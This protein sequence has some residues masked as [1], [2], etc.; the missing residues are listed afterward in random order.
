MTSTPGN[1]GPDAERDAHLLAALRHAP[2]AALEPPTSLSTR[3][4][5]HA[6]AATRGGASSA[7]RPWR[8]TLASRLAQWLAPRAPWAAAF[9]TIAAATLVGVLWSGRHPPAEDGVPQSS[10]PNDVAATLAERA[11]PNPSAPTPSAPTPPAA[12]PTPKTADAP[13]PAITRKATPAPAVAPPAP[14]EQR[15]RRASPEAQSNA[16]PTEQASPRQ[17]GGTALA[18]TSDPST[19]LDA[20]LRSA[21]PDAAV[22]RHAGR[23]HAHGGEQRLWW[24]QVGDA[25]QGRWQAV[26]DVRG[27]L[28]SAWMVL[29]IGGERT[30]AFW[31]VGD[32]L[33]LRDRA[34]VWRVPVS[35]EQRRAWEAAPQRW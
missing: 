32:V 7:S 31:F 25:T 18:T 28:P 26:S 19:R 13:A 23:V 20:A 3:I 22:W 8:T 14:P 6:S 33:W 10:A 9:G 34:G 1:G 24:S 30:A 16:A 4:L 35:A 2:D 11:V 5:A 27:D 21:A 15:A 12:A 29:S 17:S